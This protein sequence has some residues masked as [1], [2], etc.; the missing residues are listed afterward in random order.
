MIFSGQTYTTAKG[1]INK[2]NIGTIIRNYSSFIYLIQFV[3]ADGLYMFLGDMRKEIL[4]ILYFTGCFVISTF[5]MIYEIK[6]RTV[7]NVKVKHIFL[8]E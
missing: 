1:I 8:T 2:C 6:W 7:V 3:I 5:F 4:M